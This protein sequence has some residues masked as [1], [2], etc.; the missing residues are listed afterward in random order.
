MNIIFVFLCVFHIFIWSFILLAFINLKSAYINVY[1]IVPLI[2]ILHM[3]PFHILMKL[4]NHIYKNEATMI[5]KQET[6]SNWLIIPGIFDKLSK[7]LER[8]CTFSPLSPQGML[9]FGIITSI[10]RI[11]P[12]KLSFLRL[13]R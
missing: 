9:L 10:F 2:Y 6:I 4:K 1:L 7:Y 12:P 3:L 5:K 11:Y 13:N 8:K